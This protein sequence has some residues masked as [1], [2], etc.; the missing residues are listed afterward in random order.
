[1]LKTAS[2]VIEA[3]GG[4][5]KAARRL[6]QQPNTVGNWKMRGRIPPDY[7]LAVHGVLLELDEQV[8]P[9]IFGMKAV[10]TKRRLQPVR[11]PPPPSPD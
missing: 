3:L 9:D 6:G 7:F 2:E 11:R 4:T 8:S 1:M 5:T 10:S